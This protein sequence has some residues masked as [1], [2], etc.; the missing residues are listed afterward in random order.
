MDNYIEE[1]VNESDKNKNP[2]NSSNINEEAEQ[3]EDVS[4]NAE[5]GR[6]T[7]TQTGT[8]PRTTT[9]EQGFSKNA[10]TGRPTKASATAK[11]GQH[12]AATFGAQEK[13]DPELLKEWEEYGDYKLEDE[14]TPP[15]WRHRHVRRKN[16]KCNFYYFYRLKEWHYPQHFFALFAGFTLLNILIMVFAIGFICFVEFKQYKIDFGQKLYVKTVSF[17]EV[18]GE[19]LEAN[20]VVVPKSEYKEDPTKDGVVALLACWF[21]LI[22]G[23]VGYFCIFHSRLAYMGYTFVALILIQIGFLEM[24]TYFDELNFKHEMESFLVDLFLINRDRKGFL[25]DMI[26]NKFQCCGVHGAT[27]YVCLG[28]WDALCN[29]HRKYGDCATNKTEVEDELLPRMV[30]AGDTSLTKNFAA[31]KMPG[32]DGEV[33]KAF[34]ANWNEGI[35]FM[36]WTLIV[37]ALAGYMIGWVAYVEWRYLVPDETIAQYIRRRCCSKPMDKADLEAHRA[38]LAEEANR[39]RNELEAARIAK[40]AELR[41]IL[42]EKRRKEEEER[43]KRE[44][45][46]KARRE[47]EEKARLE[48]E[49]ARLEAERLAALD[50]EQKR[51]LE[52][53]QKL[54]KA[55]VSRDQKQLLMA[56]RDFRR[57]KLDDRNGDLA[58]ADRILKALHIESDLQRAVDARDLDELRRLLKII[59]RDKLE[60]EIDPALLARAKFLVERV[61]KLKEALK[62]ILGMNASTVAEL[63]SYQKPPYPVHEIMIATLM[64]VGVKEKDLKKYENVKIALNKTGKEAIKRRIGEVKPENIPM[65]VAQRAWELVKDIDVVEIVHVS[66]GAGTFLV[67]TQNMCSL[68]LEPD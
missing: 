47:A 24:I 34:Y 26:Q 56:T 17:D 42:D 9:S 43:L 64:I 14:P 68:R 8:G 30:L 23:V 61:D 44:A 62:S 54:K 38:R 12:T 50:A 31:L 48:A 20:A 22:M 6:L 32:C 52:I 65:D 29:P 25:P 7:R 13:I 10:E 18:T 37:F 63:K 33:A 39:I 21:A 15:A 53:R 27:E 19:T 57:N 11:H 28:M 2:E 55:I 4:K 46:E 40:E 58:R 49:M 36:M 5:A 45:L 60:P 59:E 1:D 41:R 16:S 51:L 67:W 3:P 66:L 35:L